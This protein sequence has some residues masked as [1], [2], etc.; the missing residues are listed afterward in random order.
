[1]TFAPGKAA[2]RT[3]VQTAPTPAAEASHKEMVNAIRML[4]ADAVEKAKSGHPGLPMGMANA[5]TVLWTRFL[6]FDPTAPEWEDRDRFILSAGHGSMLLYALLYLTG[7]E[8]VTID[9]IRNFRQLK[10]KTP[11][12]PEYGV[13]RGIETTTGPLAQGL[14]NAVGMALAERLRNA[15][16]GDEVVDHFTYCI[17]GDGCLME[18]LSQEAISLAGFLKLARLI[19]LW[20]DNR[21]SID[22]PTSL[23]T[24]D[25]QLARFEA[26]GWDAVT[27]DGEDTEA[28]A[29]AIAKAKLSDKP[30]LI[31][32][33]TTIGMGAPNKGGTAA[34]H[35]AP[36]GADEIAATRRNLGWSYP[37]F[38]VPPHILD[39]WRDA[40][41]RSVPARQAW[42]ARFAALAEDRR[43]EF[44][45]T[46]AGRLAPGWQVPLSEFKRKL[47]VDQ[48][49]WATRKASGQA[50]EILTAN[51]P[52]L[53]GGSA[54]LSE[55]VF[56]QTT[57]TTEV[58]PGD[59][60]G[61]YIHYGVREHAMAAIMNGMA[62]HGGF[63]PYGGTFLVFADYMRGAIRM[64]ALMKQRVIYVLTHD[65]IGVG[66]DGPTHHPSETLAGLRVMPNL[67]VFRPADAVETFECWVVALTEYDM[68]SC[69]ALTRQAVPA[70]RKEHESVN[71]SARGAYVLEEADCGER[72]VTLFATGSEVHVAV[73]ARERL[74]AEGIAT[75]VVSMPCWKLFDMQSE[76]YRREVMGPDWPYCVR[77]AVEAAISPGWHKYIGENGIFIGLQDFSLSAPG[78][79]LFEYFGITPDNVVANAREA[80][81]RRRTL[82]RRPAHR[83]GID[84]VG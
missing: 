19:V 11:G 75:A 83:V 80:V 42:E 62:L 21:I 81:A 53:I 52:E 65:S 72:E 32:C 78:P 71:L 48:P 2:V 35:G 54:D 7:Y 27:V 9:E 47:A 37:P 4:A 66:E 63:I 70:V 5:A 36:L 28:V 49:T 13:T 18:G 79:V 68:P 45:R 67:L 69:L 22:G 25:N 38:V 34:T 24:S 43:A 64:S 46:S 44:L 82:H 41:Q 60:T 3:E 6:R 23:S 56:T 12:H 29:A 58:R 77:I 55:S 76:R 50:L 30:S 84:V 16:W 74:E 57:H 8:D 20:D 15:R 17:V 73:K 31:A 51:F 33:R 59:Y 14:G 39:A 40:G 26:S 61:R 10:S 1:M